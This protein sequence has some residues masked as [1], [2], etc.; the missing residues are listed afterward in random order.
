MNVKKIEWHKVI[1]TLATRSVEFR[2]L[3]VKE[4]AYRKTHPKVKSLN[5]V[6]Y[7][8]LKMNY[9]TTVMHCLAFCADHIDEYMLWR[10]E[11]GL[12]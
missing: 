5:R 3:L 8:V 12:L 1:W 10:N 2:Y 6:A 11:N 7:Y 4:G 9:S